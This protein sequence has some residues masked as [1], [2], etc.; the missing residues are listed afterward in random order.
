MGILGKK[1]RKPNY[2]KTLASWPLTSAGFPQSLKSPWILGFPWKVLEND[3]VLEKSLNLGYLPWNFNWKSLISCS[4]YLNWKFE[5]IQHIKRYK[6][7]FSPKKFGSLRSQQLT[8]FKIFFQFLLLIYNFRTIVIISFLSKEYLQVHA[9][10]IYVYYV[11][12]CI[13]L[14]QNGPSLLL[15]WHNK[16]VHPPEL[17]DFVLLIKF[18]WGRTPRPPFQAE[19]FELVL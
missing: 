11:F 9:F 4:V 10:C 14:F 12:Q 16:L 6:S 15:L 19:L 1:I 7:Q 17:Q 3:F 5:W 2:I 8:S 13:N 18:F